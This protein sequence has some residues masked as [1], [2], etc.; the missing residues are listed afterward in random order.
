M[1][2]YMNL[3]INIDADLPS[4][5]TTEDN[6]R[7]FSKLQPFKHKLQLDME[8]LGDSEDEGYFQ[9]ASQLDNSNDSEETL[10]GDCFSAL[11]RIGGVR[12]T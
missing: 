7:Y 11:T 6:P 2:S 3:N 10:T 8:D 12:R 5:S 9:T 4:E 1:N